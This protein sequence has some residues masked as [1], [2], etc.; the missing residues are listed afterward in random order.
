MLKG[1]VTYF[2]DTENLEDLNYVLP[3]EVV[4]GPTEGSKEEMDRAGLKPI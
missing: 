3:L 4:Y 2:S 1:A